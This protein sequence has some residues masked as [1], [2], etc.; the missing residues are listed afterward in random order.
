MR[1]TA[2]R[3][4]KCSTDFS[5][6]RPCRRPRPPP[7][8]RP[9]PPLCFAATTM[10]CPRQ[11]APPPPPPIEAANIPVASAP[12]ARCPLPTARTL[13]HSHAR[14]LATL[15][16]S[17]HA[18]GAFHAAEAELLAARSRRHRQRSE[19]ERSSQDDLVR[20][21]NAAASHS[22][23]AADDRG[24][25]RGAA[26]AP[27]G[28]DRGAYRWWAP[29]KHLVRPTRHARGSSLPPWL[30]ELDAC[31]CA[32]T[33]MSW[34]LLSAGSF[35]AGPRG[36]EKPDRSGRHVYAAMLRYQAPFCARAAASGD[37]RE[38]G[39]GRRDPRRRVLGAPS[40]G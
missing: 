8:P 16:R 39:G 21:A 3:P 12:A 5:S 10:F 27:R 6:L 28:A 17:R 9:S 19:R 23:S 37:S 33:Y 11:H 40:C 22:A 30:V 38:R 14:V 25:G 13:R 29:H 4:A 24:A 7:P 2:R 32:H 34:G 35:L 15:V 20:L 1:R 31:T 26:L 36:P 18:H